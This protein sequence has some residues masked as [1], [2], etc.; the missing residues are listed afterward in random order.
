MTDLKR[1]LA[2]IK[3]RIQDAANSIGRNQDEIK[4]VV[5]TKEHPASAISDLYDFGI[6]DIGESYF[7]EGLEKQLALSGLKDLNWHMIGHVQSRKAEDAVLH[8]DM[9]HSVEN[10][11]LARRMDMFAKKANRE[12]QILLECN[13]SGETTKYGLPAWDEDRWPE[14]FP[15]VE[16]ILNLPNVKVHGLMSMAPYFEDGKKARPYFARTRKF[17]DMLQRKFPNADWGQLSMGM[18]GDF[19]AAIKEGATILRIGTAI[20]GPRQS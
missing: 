19:K 1:N 17:R 11:K 16:E 12:V 9:I 18:S 7:Q 6:R 4:L 15:K 2:E 10:V 20:L 8:F 13:V 14:L 5:V 3:S